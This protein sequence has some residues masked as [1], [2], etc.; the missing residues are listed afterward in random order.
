M[1]KPQLSTDLED[2]VDFMMGQE[3]PFVEETELGAVMKSMD[4]DTMDDKTMMS[5]I[6]FNSRLSEP[7]V[8]ACL[9]IDQL[10]HMGVLPANINITQGLKRLNVSLG[11]KGREEKVEIVVGQRAQQSGS[12]VMG[13]LGS[14]FQKKQ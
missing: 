10:K 3:K 7:Q 1:S 11:G 14:L 12:G 2:K 6:D 9:V 13:K 5:S 8:G 4:S